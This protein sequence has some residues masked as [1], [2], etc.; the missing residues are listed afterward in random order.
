LCK[1]EGLKDI[2]LYY[3]KY[4]F[5]GQKHKLLILSD[6]HIGSKYTPHEWII[7]AIKEGE[8][9]G[10]EMLLHAGDVVDGLCPSRIGTHIFELE[11][12]GYRA[13]RDRAIELF[14]ECSIP[15]YFISGNHDSWYSSGTGANIVEDF[16]DRLPNATYLGHDSADITFDNVIVRLHHGLD[17]NSYSKSYR[18][19]KL[20]EAITGGKKP[21]IMLCGHVH[22]YCVTMERHIQMISLPSMQMQTP[23]MRGKRINAETGFIIAEFTVNEYGIGSFKHEFIPFYG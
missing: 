2:S 5:S 14:Q 11:D 21:N 23:W 13:Q 7:D 3:P 17:G 16:C 4:N 6:T 10:C 9:Q 1:G 15:M 22:K 18:L 19:Q 8:R 20:A 12:I